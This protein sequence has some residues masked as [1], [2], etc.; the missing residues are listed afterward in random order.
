M[1]ETCL[2]G[3]VRDAPSP[4][5][6]KQLSVQLAPTGIGRLA[7]GRHPAASSAAAVSSVRGPVER[8]IDSRVQRLR[9]LLR[10]LGRVCGVE[11]L[12]SDGDGG[13]LF[14]NLAFLGKLAQLVGLRGAVGG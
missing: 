11:G 14:T 12:E 4:Q 8:A 7:A 3:G 5:I 13:E 2:R 9:V 1:G 6:G 10:G